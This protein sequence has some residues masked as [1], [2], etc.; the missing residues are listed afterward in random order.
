MEEYINYVKISGMLD[1]VNRTDS[2]SFFV[3][4]VQAGMIGNVKNEH[5]YELYISAKDVHIQKLLVAG[6]WYI[7][8]GK[9]TIFKSRYGHKMLV[10]V[11]NMISLED[12]HPDSDKVQFE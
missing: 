11:K 2:G 10:H 4:L 6:L 7:V 9:L 12:N 8:E 1:K 3:R 5:F